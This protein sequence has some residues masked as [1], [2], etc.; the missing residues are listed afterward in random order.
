MQTPCY[1]GMNGV[2]LDHADKIVWIINR[3]D[4]NARAE[5]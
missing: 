4:E 5:A 3:L 1:E 2:L